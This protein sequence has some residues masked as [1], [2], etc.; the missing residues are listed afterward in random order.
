MAVGVKPEIVEVDTEGDPSVPA[1]PPAENSET[2]GSDHMIP[3]RRFDQVNERAKKYKA[4][5]DALEQARVEAEKQAAVEKGEFKELYEKA[6]ADANVYRAEAV[7]MRYDQL[8]RKVAEENGI[9]AFWN[10]LQGEDEESLAQDAASFK[11]SLPAS[12]PQAPPPD[13][14]SG[15]RDRG[16]QRHAATPQEIAEQ[17][18]RLGVNPEYLKRGLGFSD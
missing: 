12:A 1:P 8:R 3:K 6:L 7:A 16:T 14:G 10:R 5:L 13:G 17:A 2:D 4:E 11:E 18:A 15:F 9:G